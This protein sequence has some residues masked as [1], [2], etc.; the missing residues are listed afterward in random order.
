MLKFLLPF[1][2]TMYSAFG[3]VSIA[4]ADAFPN[5]T[6]IFNMSKGTATIDRGGA[7][8]SQARS[9]YSLGGGMVSAKGKS[10]TLFSFDP[11]SFSAG[12]AGVSWHFGG[13]AFISMDEIRQLVEAVAQASLGVA[14]DLAMQTLC[15]QCYA[16]MSK[17]RDIANMMRNATADACGMAK[18]LGEMAKQAFTTNSAG[19]QTKC[20]DLQTSANKDDS[21]LQS[22]AGTCN[23]LDKAQDVVGKASASMEKYLQGRGSGS[24]VDSDLLASMGNL[25]HRQL[26][27]LGYQDGF[28]KDFLLSMMGMVVMKPSG[29]SCAGVLSGAVTDESLNDSSLSP[30]TKAA[31]AALMNKNSSSSASSEA[32]IRPK[33]TSSDGSGA[34]SSASASVSPTGSKKGPVFCYAPPLFTDFSELGSVLM[35]GV[36]REAEMQT[37]ANTYF[38]S[39]SVAYVG[40][41]G[42]GTT[43]S[44]STGSSGGASPMARLMEN[45]LGQLCGAERTKQLTN[46]YMYS[47]RGGKNGECTNPSVVRMGEMLDQ[48]V[49]GG[50][51]GSYTGLAWIMAD[52][53]YRGIFKIRDGSGPLDA[54]TVA[55]LNGVGWPL[56]R[57]LNTAAVYPG[58]AVDT[59]TLY[60]VTI[61]ETFALDSILM[62]AS[63]GAQPAITTESHV[64]VAPEAVNQLRTQIANMINVAKGSKDRTPE[65]MAKKRQLIETVVQINKTIQTEVLTRGLAG[66]AEMSI[67]LKKSSK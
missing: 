36:N 5:P 21:F 12:C 59:L 67:N 53:L 13:F 7:I 39:K 9:I 1:L 48:A 57:L 46:P 28:T 64:G 27:A 42:S 22:W 10:V 40:A 50:G 6:A 41:P 51:N 14:V 31:L 26:V 16:V 55:L 25:T 19:S 17:L 37:F 18:Q 34:S 65:F 58:Q 56:Y 4:R 47:C 35:C 52:A 11:P 45:P 60:I 8:D 54:D 3:L 43:G 38:G 20:A 32:T 33:D 44:A 24:P 30:E 23:T 29:S 63:V 49:M 15:P 66:N 2:L 61:V 62:T